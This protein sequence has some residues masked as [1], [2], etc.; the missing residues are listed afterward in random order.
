MDNTEKLRKVFASSL[1]IPETEV[2]DDLAYGGTKKWDSTAHMVLVSNIEKS[3]DIMLD[4][5]DVIDM[6]S[7]GKCKEILLKYGLTFT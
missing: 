6:S 1:G 3:F 4:T 5:M 7:F 2:V